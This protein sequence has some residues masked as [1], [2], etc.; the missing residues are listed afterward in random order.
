MTAHAIT[1]EAVQ[2]FAGQLAHWIDRAPWAE[3]ACVDRDRQIE[4]LLHEQ[5]VLLEENSEFRKR[6]AKRGKARR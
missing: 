1:P 6:P 2:I 4:G 3:E 5:A